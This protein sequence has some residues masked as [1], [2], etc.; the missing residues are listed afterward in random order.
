MQDFVVSICCQTYNHKNYISQ[1]IESFLMQK[2]D[3]PF[4]ILL[5]DDASTDGTSEICR[6]YANKYPNVINLLAYEENQLQKGISPFRDNVKRACGKYIAICEGDDYWN[7]ELKLQKQVNFM[8][9]NIEYS[10]VCH[11]ALVIN[12][13]TG[14][15]SYFFGIDH[16]KQICSTKDVFGLHFCPTASILFRKEAAWLEDFYTKA[17]AGDMMLVLLLSLKGLLYRMND[18]MC[19]YR[20]TASGAT[21]V[22]RR[23]ILQ[24][25]VNR[26]EMFKHFDK[27]SNFKFKKYINIE[28]LLLENRIRLSNTK[29]KIIVLVLKIYMKILFMRRKKLFA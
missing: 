29:S 11:N 10:M 16:K 12:E 28:I 6:E 27:V 22:N 15:S 26:I 20:R 18:V 19:V 17:F 3:F 13:I 21:Q 4:E 14:T 24:S 8:E 23:R 25:W 5:R 1:T 9:K 7:D 2:T